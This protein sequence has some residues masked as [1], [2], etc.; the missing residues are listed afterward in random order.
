MAPSGDKNITEVVDNSP[1]LDSL[2]HI[3]AEGSAEGACEINVLV[4]DI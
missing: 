4:Y 3:E 2:Y 1:N